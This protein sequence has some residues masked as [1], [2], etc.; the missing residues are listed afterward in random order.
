[1]RKERDN[2]KLLAVIAIGAMAISALLTMPKCSNYERDIDIKE[3]EVP[4]DNE[5][6][7]EYDLNRDYFA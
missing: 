7:Q 3:E 4:R 1:M 5:H 2:T 6:K